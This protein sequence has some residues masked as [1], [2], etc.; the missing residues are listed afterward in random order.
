MRI[1]Q[2]VLITLIMGSQFSMAG[3]DM[4][5]N[6]PKLDKRIVK[7]YLE[8]DLSGLSS[9]HSLKFS[10]AGE[11]RLVQGDT[12]SLSIA[13]KPEII[14]SIEVDVVDN[15]L[16]INVK[17]KLLSLQK[18][19]DLT[20]DV[21]IPSPKAIEIDGP[22]DIRMENINTDALDISLNGSGSVKAERLAS[23]SLNLASNGSGKVKVNFITADNLR[24]TR[25]GSGELTV[26]TLHCGVCQL[27]SNGSGDINM[28]SLSGG[29]LS[30]EQGGSGD[31]FVLSAGNIESQ[32]I[33]LNGSG[34]YRAP[35][36]VSR[37]ARANVKGSGVV[38]FNVTSTLEAKVLGSG[39]VLY[40]GNPAN[41]K[42]SE[43][44]VG[45]VKQ[46]I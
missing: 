33:D 39:Q 17:K 24:L 37:N 1:Q 14:D 40:H 2:L 32:S 42:A 30:V 23:P 5:K 19:G 45:E 3:N 29:E 13:A 28:G 38:E 21:V 16:S 8:Q 34:R 11:V 18:N 36:L 10:T 41:V 26:D 22:G 12:P 27:K 4:E 25:L 46:S 44:G 31:I 15:R 7:T 43:K 6:S 35:Q 9:I 20:I